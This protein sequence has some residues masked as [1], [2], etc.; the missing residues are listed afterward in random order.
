MTVTCRVRDTNA[1]HGAKSPTD[2]KVDRAWSL[3]DPPM[4]KESLLAALLYPTCK[5]N[6]TN[7]NTTPP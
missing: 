3:L 7:T 5:H 4:S 1:A 6:V 2:T